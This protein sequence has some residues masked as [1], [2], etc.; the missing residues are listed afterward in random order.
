M[1]TNHKKTAI[2]LFNLGGPD[3]LKSVKPFLFNL[4]YDPAIIRL[5]NPFRWVVAK[6]ISTLRDKKAQNIYSTI[7]G[8]SSLLEETQKQK[9]ALES[10]L[11][12]KLAGEFK[13][14][15]CMRHWHPRAPEVLKNIEDF[16]PTEII[17][18]PLYPQFSTTTSGSSIKEFNSLLALNENLKKLPLKTICCYFND[19]KFIDAHVSLILEATSKLASIENQRILFSAH[20]LPKKIIDAGDPYQWQIEQTVE[21]IINKLQIPNLDYK[22]T[23][24]SRAT[25]VEWLKPDTEDEIKAAYL[26]KK[27]LIIV[28]VAFVSEHVETLVELDIEYKALADRDKI[29]YIRVPTLGINN[30]F[31]EA[32]SDM[33]VNFSKNKQ[34]LKNCK[35]VRSC[36]PHFTDCPCKI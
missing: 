2:V 7:G 27:S 26:M 32:T 5:P 4:F 36:L 6:I 31:I 12:S 8:K 20:G 30:I 10:A 18:V 16:N 11:K 17:S 24:Q 28:P 29:Q 14:F 15:I 25:P 33:I 21:K 23:Y 34:Q 19:E 1:I 3:S 22:I 13:I 9:N 35:Q